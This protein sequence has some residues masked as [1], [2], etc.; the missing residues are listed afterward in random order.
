MDMVG[1]PMCP[2]ARPSEGSACTTVIAD[3]VYDEIE[4]DCE[5][6]TWSCAEPVDP[7]CPAAMPAHGSACTAPEATECDF[8]GD[9]CECLSG[10]WS[11][12]SAAA[13]GGVTA[14]AGPMDERCPAGRPAEDSTC[15]MSDV[16]CT[17]DENTCLCPAGTWQCNEPVDMGC[18]QSAPVDG[19]PC[20]GTADCDFLDLE[21]ECLSSAWDCKAND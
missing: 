1:A 13:D 12:D 3:C 9:E 11:C 6:G 5:A 4:C 7:N 8:L 20:T 14:D 15:T 18:P 2:A 10:L 16:S 21:C 17:Y 19:S